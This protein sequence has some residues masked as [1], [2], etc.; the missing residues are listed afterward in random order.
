MAQYHFHAIRHVYHKVGILEED[1]FAFGPCEYPWESSQQYW[2]H[3]A[4][5]SILNA[6]FG[7]TDGQKIRKTNRPH[8]LS[9]V[10]T[11]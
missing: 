10:G 3:I 7:E 9:I 1:Y 11:Q 8:Q 4:N 2:E 5:S 6:S